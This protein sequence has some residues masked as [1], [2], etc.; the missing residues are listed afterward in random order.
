[1]TK[2]S[3]FTLIELIVVILILSILA[4]TAL[5]RFIDVQDDAHAA[6]VAGVG[7]AFSSGIALA[8]A[9]WFVNGTGA[10]GLVAGYGDSTG[11]VYANSSG[12]PIDD[13]SAT[14]DCVALWG[15]LLQA[16]APG[17]S[18]TAGADD[19]QGVATGTQ[20]AYTY[21]ANTNLSITYE[22]ATGVVTIDSDP[23]S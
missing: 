10:A 23:S 9:Q 16:G 5:P 2:Q 22:S 3:G 8:H 17:V 7:G 11:T 21:Q 4:A 19:Y 18:A 14:L 1:M 15:G 13:N 6:A 20:C 12:W